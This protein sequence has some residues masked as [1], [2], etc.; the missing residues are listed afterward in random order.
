MM[1]KQRGTKKSENIHTCIVY[2]P[3][4]DTGAGGSGPSL[5]GVAETILD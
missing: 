4:A 1:T 5:V 2:A 3:A